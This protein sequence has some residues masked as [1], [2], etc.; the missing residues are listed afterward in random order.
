MS[1]RGL[2]LDVHESSSTQPCLALLSC[3]CLSHA[4]GNV[5]LTACESGIFRALAVRMLHHLQSPVA[6]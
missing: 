1:P 2:R 3:C 6:S 4:K 5:L